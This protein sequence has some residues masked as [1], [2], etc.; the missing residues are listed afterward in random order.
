[1]LD[2]STKILPSLFQEL[3]SGPHLVPLQETKWSC[4]QNIH[5][6]SSSSTYRELSIA[7]KMRSFLLKEETILHSLENYIKIRRK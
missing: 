5:S 2:I 1:M 3:L 7:G 6:S 4:F